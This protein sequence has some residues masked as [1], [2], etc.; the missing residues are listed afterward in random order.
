[1]N[2]EGTGFMPA[3]VGSAIEAME[4]IF[5]YSEYDGE[6]MTFSTSQPTRNNEQL[7]LNVS[8][9]TRGGLTT[10]D[11]AILN[12]NEGS[13]LPKFQLDENSA[14]VYI[15]QNGLDYAVVTAEGQGEMPVNF[16]ADENGL[17]T[18][19][20][21]YE[22][23][24]F[25]YLHLFDNKTGTDVDLL[26]TPSYTFNATT[27]DYESRFKLVYATGS[28]L[29]DDS[30]SFINSNGNFSIFGIEGEATLQV[31]DMMG[32]MLSTETFNGSIEKRL[33][34][35]PGVYFIRL[36]NGDDVK[37]QKVVVR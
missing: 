7:S 14:K 16:R 28:S 32:R 17:Y 13:G 31:L 26:N 34:V 8:K 21:S 33:D 25:S 37:T 15:P 2:E 19:N 1:M 5:V 22:N 35:A 27:T 24:E 6:I 29:A 10:I 3:T 23:V 4:G 9:M 30:F 18:L 36:V 20:F 12:F 11:R